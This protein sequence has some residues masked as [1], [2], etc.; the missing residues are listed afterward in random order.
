ML[1]GEHAR[2][3]KGGDFHWRRTRLEESIAHALNVWNLQT[4][5]NVQEC[6]NVVL[7]D[8]KVGGVHIVQHLSDATDI[9]NDQVE[10]LVLLTG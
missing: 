5:S 4:L 6:L 3:R 7:V 10:D 9:L 1:R 8:F 2:E